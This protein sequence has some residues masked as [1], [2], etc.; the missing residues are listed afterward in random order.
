MKK[1][2]AD[3]WLVGSCWA[4]VGL[5]V[6]LLS[7]RA[8]DVRAVQEGA[9]VKVTVDGR[10]LLEYRAEQVPF[11][12]YVAQLTSPSG[13]QVLR[14]SPFDHKHHHGLMFAVAADGVNFWE[15]RP[16]SGRE[17]HRELDGPTLSTRDGVSLASFGERLDWL[18]PNQE[19]LVREARQ[20]TVFRQPGLDATLL[21]WSTRLEPA[22]GK[23]EVKL[24][25]SSYF[26]LGM[27]FRESMDKVGR[28]LWA[29]AKD[30]Q[31]IHGD[32][33]LT[34]SSWC[35]YTGPIDGKP[36]SV[37]LFDHPANPRHPARM[38]SMVTPFAYLSATLDLAQQPLVIRQDRPL[39]VRYGVAVWDGKIEPAQVEAL[40]RVWRDLEP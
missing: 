17:V 7:C 25:G 33:R 20:V 6:P 28:S 2:V 5:A 40:Y 8:A 16:Q 1:V 23:V 37:A 32:T 21:S 27:R 39:A 38:F 12:P 30:S 14:D 24:S 22:A 36:M 15:E 9:V 34:H 19:A 35:A 10:P 18:G 4:L 29:D 3:A 26:G 31:V 11:K 13:V